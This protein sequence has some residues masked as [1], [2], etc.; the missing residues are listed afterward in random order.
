MFSLILRAYRRLIDYLERKLDRKRR[1]TG[2]TRLYECICDPFLK[3]ALLVKLLHKCRVSGPLKLAWRY[4]ELSFWQFSSLRRRQNVTGLTVAQPETMLLVL[5]ARLAA[6][7]VRLVSRMVSVMQ[8][9]TTLHTAVPARIHHG[10]S[11]IAP[12]HVIPVRMICHGN[13]QP[14]L[15]KG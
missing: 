8:R 14:I 7:K 3:Q 5:I 4:E 9:D 2:A 12:G 6:S 10:R 13:L 11:P 1:E 15:S